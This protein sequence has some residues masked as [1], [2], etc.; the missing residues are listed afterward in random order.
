LWFPKISIPP[1]NSEEEGVLKAK[2]FEKKYESK[3]EFPEGWSVQTQKNPPW[4]EYG[5]FLEQHNLLLMIRGCSSR[6]ERFN[7]KRAFW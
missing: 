3:L 7:T 1:P 5:Y 6:S 4:G 2:I